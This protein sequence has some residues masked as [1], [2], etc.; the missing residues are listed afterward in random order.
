[1]QVK[2]FQAS[3]VKEAIT[4]VKDQL[5]PDAIILSVKDNSKQ[6]G[7]SAEPIEVTA[8]VSEKRVAQYK[9]A[10][11]RMT[12]K[13]RTE[14][15]AAPATV[16]KQFIQKMA[17]GHPP[18]A[19]TVQPA[20]KS[21]LKS[22]AISY[23]DIVD[24]EPNPQGQST[25]SIKEKL[26][27]RIEAHLPHF[28]QSKVTPSL[29]NETPVIQSLRQEIHDL[30]NSLTELRSLPS[31]AIFPGAERGVE[32]DLSFMFQHLKGVGISDEVAAQLLTKVQSAMP[33]KMLNHRPSVVGSVAK[34]ILDNLMIVK[35]PFERKIHC[36]IG[37]PAQ[38]KTSMVIKM[39][40]HLNLALK[41]KVA[42]G[43]TLQDKIGSR[44]QLKTYARILNAPYFEIS[45]P[46]DWIDQ[47]HFINGADY[48]LIDFPGTTPGPNSN[49]DQLRSL[50]PPY[51]QHRTIHYVASL[52]TK[53]SDLQKTAEKFQKIGFDDVI[54]TFLDQT[55]QHGSILNFQQRFE[56]PLHSFGVGPKIPEDFELATKERVLDLLLEIRK[57]IS[58]ILQPNSSSL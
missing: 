40:S 2:K 5:G 49:I 29:Q 8:A 26:K 36:F 47:V 25:D 27:H 15:K 53:D 30:K 43:C 46:Q 44:E 3:S 21:N 10:E 12:E 23:I 9:A 56:V 11:S 19:A 50:L 4:K 52:A 39:A 24:E 7:R 28:Q 55:Q 54:F 37:G 33:P 6:Y 34:Q 58:Q 38:G 16:Q 31:R 18:P 20:L 42:I 48:V 35:E 14:F 41:K 32:F 45:G 22:S 51:D 17:S 1:M 13:R 57:G